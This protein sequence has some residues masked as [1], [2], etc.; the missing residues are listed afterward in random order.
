MRTYLSFEFPVAGLILP[1]VLVIA[2]V[3]LL[4]RARQR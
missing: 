1:I 2:G 3:F 4:R